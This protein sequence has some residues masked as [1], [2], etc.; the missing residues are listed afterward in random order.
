MR[1]RVRRGAAILVAAAAPAVPGAL[2]EQLDPAGGRLVM[3]VGPR[4]RQELHRVV[5]DGDEWTETKRRPGRVRAAHRRGWLASVTV[6]APATL[7]IL[8]RP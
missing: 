7:G 3:P 1:R 4:D 8:G 2:R 5:R 6:E